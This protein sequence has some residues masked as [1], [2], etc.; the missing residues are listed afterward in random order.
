MAK[1]IQ[2]AFE[3]M[4][5]KYYLRCRGCLE[6]AD[7]WIVVIIDCEFTTNVGRLDFRLDFISTILF[8]S[9]VF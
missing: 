4:E 8:I 6:V 3:D 1:A 9:L 2:N 5:L 7:Q